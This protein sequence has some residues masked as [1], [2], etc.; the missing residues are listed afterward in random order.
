MREIGE[1]NR[2]A[3]K[4]QGE[5]VTWAKEA[6]R[7]VAES[8]VG[9]LLDNLAAD[10]Q[11][12]SSL[13]RWLVEMRVDLMDNLEIFLPAQE[14]PC[15]PP[16]RRSGATRSISWSTTRTPR[17][18][19]WWSRPIR[20]T[21]TSSAASSTG[22]SPAAACRPIS[23]WFV[24]ARCTAPTAGSWCCAP[25]RWPCRRSPGSRSR[26]RCATRSSCSRNCTAAAACR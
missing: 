5:F 3:A 15:R 16:N 14:G 20:P 6:N 13:T 7:Q 9:G 18:R 19:P 11:S 17:A 8:A 26:A 2:W 4:R 12:Y 23:R 1:I 21:R 25:R 24:P 22:R 10:Y